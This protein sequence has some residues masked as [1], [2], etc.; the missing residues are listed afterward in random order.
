[1]PRLNA[2]NNAETTLSSAISDSSTSLTVA[3]GA[4]FPAAPFLIS[5]DDEIIE[6]GTKNGNT[7]SS[8][9]RGQEGT[10]AAVHAQGAKVENRF[11]AGAY[12]ELTTKAY[13]DNWIGNIASVLE[14]V[15]DLIG[16]IASALDAINGEAI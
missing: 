8:L 2:A 9:L 7:F 3:S 15:D 6:V 14:D 12:N 16:D 5:I 11:T 13:V 10:T 1:V 4:A